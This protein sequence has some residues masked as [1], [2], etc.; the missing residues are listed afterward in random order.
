[1]TPV[2]ER[3]TVAVAL[4]DP[5]PGDRVLE[6]GCGRGAGAELV[7]GRLRGR[8]TYVGLDRSPAAIAAASRRVAGHLDAG[9]A[10]FVPAALADAD[11]GMGPFSA[12][13]AV[14][15]NLFWTGPARRELDVLS[16]L[17]AP[18]G[19]VLLSFAPPDPAAIDR[20]LES[21]RIHL[22][23]AGWGC[24]ART[25]PLR[26]SVLLAVDARPP[27]GPGPGTASR[28]Q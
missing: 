19:R 20:L 13:L 24:D 14:D 10:R 18:R 3:L 22:A 25:I 15:V 12:V 9:T 26:G 17:L 2:P 21:V 28:R 1:M 16:A 7:L 27:S 4:L 11:P 23:D 8:G 6:I 5:V